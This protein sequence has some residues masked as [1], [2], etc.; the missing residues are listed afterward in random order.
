[1][2]DHIDIE[3]QLIH[4]GRGIAVLSDGQ[5][6]PIAGWL[7][8][9]GECDADEA[10]ACVCGPCFDGKWYSVNLQEFDAATIN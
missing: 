10:T 8:S 1:M 3:V 9:G 4:R 2:P 5:E 7:N 6:V